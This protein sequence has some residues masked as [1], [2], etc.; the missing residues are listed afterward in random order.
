MEENDVWLNVR[1]NASVRHTFVPPA[2]CKSTN[3]IPAESGM[4][5]FAPLLVPR[6]QL[7][8][9]FLLVRQLFWPNKS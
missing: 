7:H 6:T 4:M 8:N 5:V 2:L 1:V 3:S 9:G